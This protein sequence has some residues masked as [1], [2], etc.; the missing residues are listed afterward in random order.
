MSA[1]YLTSKVEGFE[2]PCLPTWIN[3][4]QVC[5]R[6]DGGVSGF[7]KRVHLLWGFPLCR[8]GEEF[9]GIVRD[10]R[11]VQSTRPTP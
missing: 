3:R 5:V 2:G 4:N 10:R 7:F 1:R 11:T 8:Y 9:H 6:L